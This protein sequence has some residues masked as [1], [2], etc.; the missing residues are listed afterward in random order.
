M[1]PNPVSLVA[2]DKGEVVEYRGLDWMIAGITIVVDIMVIFDVI[3]I[4]GIL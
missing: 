2:F 1:F 3:I 4:N